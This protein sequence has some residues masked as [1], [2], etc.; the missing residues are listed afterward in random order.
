MPGESRAPRDS[1]QLRGDGR[2]R[3]TA[4]KDAP[5]AQHFVLTNAVHPLPQE[6]FRTSSGV[7]PTPRAVSGWRGCQTPPPHPTWPLGAALLLASEASEENSVGNLFL[8]SV[9]PMS[10]IAKKIAFVFFIKNIMIVPPGCNIIFMFPHLLLL[11]VN[12]RHHG[13]G[14][15]K[16]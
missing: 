11:Y 4:N 9:M 14:I 7:L 2:E 13:M 16:K 6:S 8:P 1:C 10:G 3:P 15:F 5:G 12:P